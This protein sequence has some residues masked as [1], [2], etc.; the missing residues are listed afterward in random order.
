[1]NLLKKI[2]ERAKIAAQILEFNIEFKS[3]ITE[4]L[5]VFIATHPLFNLRSQGVTESEALKWARIQA[6]AHFFQHTNKALEVIRD[7]EQENKT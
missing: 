4:D 2:E 1:M 6:E 5:D 7:Y 3:G